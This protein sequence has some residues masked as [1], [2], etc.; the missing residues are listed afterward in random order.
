MLIFLFCSILSLL[1]LFSRAVFFA[2]L[3][4]LKRL[5]FCF[6]QV[7]FEDVKKAWFLSTFWKKERVLE[8]KKK[9][10]LNFVHSF[11]S[12]FSKSNNF[13]AKRESFTFFKEKEAFNFEVFKAK[14]LC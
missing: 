10:G 14:S 13:K 5:F 4:P 1:F 12:F 7:S 3:R 6:R 9:E 2:R 8:V 11:S